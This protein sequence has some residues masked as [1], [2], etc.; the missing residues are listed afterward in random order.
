MMSVR[1]SES[2]PPL[3]FMGARTRRAMAKSVG[4]CAVCAVIGFLRIALAAPI[5]ARSL[6]IVACLC[7][8]SAARHPPNLT[9]RPPKL[10]QSCHAMNSVRHTATNRA[11]HSRSRDRS[12]YTWTHFSW[13]KTLVFKTYLSPHGDNRCHVAELFRWPRADQEMVRRK[14]GDGY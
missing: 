3:R 8:R 6:P 14:D 2:E 11:K 5:A 9:L 10:S 12:R 13:N 4:C 1:E 7:P